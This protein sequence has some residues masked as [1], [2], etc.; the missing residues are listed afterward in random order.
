MHSYF[1]QS[2]TIKELI[3]QELI[4]RLNEHLQD[5]TQLP[6]LGHGCHHEHYSLG[7][8]S[9]GTWVATRELRSRHKN[10]RS[11]H[12]EKERFEEYCITAEQ[13]I[14]QHCIV[15]SFCVGASYTKNG[16]THG[17]LLVEDLTHGL[18]RELYDLGQNCVLIDD[19]RPVFVDLSTDIKLAPG[20]P[21]R[22]GKV[23][24]IQYMHDDHM[25]RF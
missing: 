6:L 2:Q 23:Q 14:D 17:L 7:Q 16:I 8:L 22:S 9:N 12:D 20:Q 15:P 25:I 11:L 19:D 18:Q 10:G 5:A 4:E 3:E 24:K 21:Y 13:K 1:S